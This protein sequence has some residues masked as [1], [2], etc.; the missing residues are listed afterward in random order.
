MIRHDAIH[1][2]KGDS[3]PM[4]RGPPPGPALFS[5]VTTDSFHSNDDEHIDPQLSG[6][7]SA[8]SQSIIEDESESETDFSFPPNHLD[9]DYKFIWPECQGLVGNAI[10]M[11]GQPRRFHELVFSQQFDNQDRSPVD[12]FNNT[13]G[14][15]LSGPG[16]GPIDP[17]LDPSLS[18][19]NPPSNAA[20]IRND[21][22]PSAFLDRCLEAYFIHFNVSFPVLHRPTFTIQEYAPPVILGAMAIGSLFIDEAGVRGRGE[23]LWT[24][25]NA[26]L[27]ASEQF[28]LQ[29]RGPYNVCEGVQL[30]LTILF[31]RIYGTF[32][33]KR[34]IRDS[35][36][37]LSAAAFSRATQC[38][39]FEATAHYPG[40]APSATEQDQYREWRS[41]LACEI[42][43]RMLLAH[44]II[45]GISAQIS[46]QPAPFRSTLD[47]L[48]LPCSDALFAADSPAAWTKQKTLE[49]QETPSISTFGDFFSIL[50][51]QI[52]VLAVPNPSIPPFLSPLSTSVALAEIQSR[53]FECSD[54]PALSFGVAGKSDIRRAMFQLHEHI[55]LQPEQ[56]RQLLLLRWH[57]VCLDLLLS[58]SI[59]SGALCNYLSLPT[60]VF[61]P[62]VIDPS[63]LCAWPSTKDGRTALLHAAAIRDIAS[64]SQQQT[65][66]D[67]T[68]STNLFATTDASTTKAANQPP[69]HPALH[70]PSS[71]LAAAVVHATFLLSLNTYNPPGSQPT[72]IIL[73][74][75]EAL[76]R[77]SWQD[78]LFTDLDPSIVLGDLAK[79]SSSSGESSRV[80]EFIHG[81]GGLTDPR[82]AGSGGLSRPGNVDGIQ[83]EGTVERDLR[84]DLAVLR[85]MLGDVGK[86]WGVATEMGKVVEAWIGA[87]GGGGP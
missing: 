81:G 52:G 79:P 8:P 19:I 58:T 48:P 64:R 12:P 13:Q 33:K 18:S 10:A 49:Q 30:V 39:L 14:S 42:Q 24:L 86:T 25:V 56:P 23:L 3:A 7:A 65:H 80:R 1:V 57:S 15:I 73:P 61:E 28:L 82:D 36:R 51:P 78:A 16:G 84:A 63:E 5:P 53:V 29:H 55:M 60:R 69:H 45:D 66:S 35:S 44:Y 17:T 40:I 20:T 59:L 83:R 50:F 68:S 75:I 67:P 76:D 31:C 2:R 71:L 87:V 26:T 32:S 37:A 77:S 41:W 74:T 9:I 21:K 43:L 22:L 34:S 6:L 38:G 47:S 27:E 62:A 4:P 54:E 11:T 46:G 85:D 72:T 70:A